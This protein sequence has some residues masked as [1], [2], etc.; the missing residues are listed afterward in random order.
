MDRDSALSIVQKQMTEKRFIHT[1][2]VVE[3]AIKLAKIYGVDQKKAELAAIFHDYAKFR[4]V[5]EMK[6]IV[7]K[8]Q[9]DDALLVYGDELLHGPVGAFLVKNEVGIH[10]EDILNGIRYHT[11]GRA[12][13]TMLEKVI[14]IADYIEPNR[15]FTGVEEVRELAFKDIHQALIVS[16][17]NTINFLLSKKQPVFPSTLAAY[18]FLIL[19]EE[20]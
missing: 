12:R 14:Y 15:S 10:D 2:G 5:D 6:E 4:P 19:K 1:Q 9:M 11:T 3:T 7:V 18:N 20:L 17:S 8:E 16:I 13:M